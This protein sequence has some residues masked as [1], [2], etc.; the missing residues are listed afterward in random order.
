MSKKISTVKAEQ[1]IIVTA[2]K[3]RQM[4]LEEG[5]EISLEEAQLVLDFLRILAKIVVK[6]YLR[7]HE[8]SKFVCEG[9]H[10]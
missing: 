6:H 10:G 9:E 3:A 2:Q 8:N 1:N 4:L 5:I 7:E